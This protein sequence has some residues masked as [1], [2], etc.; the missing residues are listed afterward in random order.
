MSSETS[1]R[2]QLRLRTYL[3]TCTWL[4]L[5][6]V[7]AACSD[8]G[9]ATTVDDTDSEADSDTETSSSGPSTITVTSADSSSTGEPTGSTGE[10]S[11]DG[12]SDA[13][14]D[15]S[16]S[17]DADSSSSDTGVDPCGNG[18]IG[19]DEACDGEALGGATCESEGFASG[20]LAC[21]ADCSELDTTACVP[22]SCG[23][24][25]INGDFEACDGTDIDT[26]CAAE[27][28]GAGTVSC[29]VGCQLDLSACCGDGS[30]GG[31]ETCDGDDLGGQTCA[32]QGE[33]D[34]GTLL[35]NAECAGFDV[36]GCTSCG[37]G[38]IE[39]AEQCEGDNLDGQSCTTVPG[40]F[41]GGTLACDGCAFDTSGCN[42]CG[43][44]S[45]DAGEVCDGDDLGASDCLA[46][47]FTGGTV[48]C[49]EDCSYD[50]ELCTAFAQ[51][52]IGDVVIT[53]IMRDPVA[54]PDASGEWFEITN[55]S[56]D[57]IWQ[58]SGCVFQD[59]G[60]DDFAVDVDL[61]IA[62][63]EYLTFASSDAPGFTP[64]FVYTGMSLSQ[65]A[66]GDELELIC[67]LV[68]VDRV[69]FDGGGAAIF[70]DAAG[71][72][73]QLDP[74][75]TDAIAND[76]GTSWCDA[77]SP[78][79]M[80]D[81]GTPGLANDSCTAPELT[82]DF[83]NVQ[84]PLTIDDDVG[85]SLEVYGRVYV[86]GQTDQSAGND[87]S[88]NLQGWLGYG[89][90]GSDPALDATWV[91]TAA[92]PNPAWIGIGDPDQNNDEYRATLTL[93]ADGSYDY[94]YRFSGD[95]GSTFS[96][97]DGGAGSSDG[98]AADD[99]GQLTT[100]VGAGDASLLYISEYHEGT[101]MNYKAIEIYNP[102]ADDVNVASCSY[103]LY[104][105]GSAVPTVTLPL[106]GVAESQGV[107]VL[108]HPDFD[109]IFDGCDQVAG[110]SF[111]GDDA[112]ELYCDGASNDF[113]GQ[114]GVD[115]GAAWSVNGVS[116]A[117]QDLRRA[118]GF[119]GD[120]DGSNAF[121]P[122]L[123]WEAFAIDTDIDYLADDF[124]Q[125]ACP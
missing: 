41:V 73:M 20:T 29:T 110:L 7:I 83:C 16:S 39:G 105:N 80:A 10:S 124:G 87:P 51:P 68:S 74:T 11:S 125:H 21:A 28:F 57:T 48:A 76:T 42:F 15:S 92:A 58:L 49:F 40:G 104:G 89:P 70:P 30:V 112:I 93:P 27:G 71:A 96:Y 99:A 12:S 82:I 33:F 6:A 101:G 23:D 17:G 4:S 102:G 122:S 75:A 116:T 19:E 61:T 123:E 18:R 100:S 38:A 14:L 107:F 26:D 52:G 43:N 120:A 22:A 85:V 72:A 35:C 95:G 114:T 121:E 78:F 62:P 81:T 86:A 25:E 97:C 56:L 98:Y 53:E 8:D 31:S 13:G 118:C 91:W 111:N 64:D 65:A 5:A 37:D 1:M 94:A 50:T 32:L 108:C 59:D 34:G 60:M 113:I 44:D 69:A 3:N 47:G 106:V 109:G 79:F 46:L 117:D 45:V 36:A 67:N 24:N 66:A 119:T 54:T 9:A 2:L 115:P 77:F 88:P 103:R 90:D 55:T 63:G 84:F